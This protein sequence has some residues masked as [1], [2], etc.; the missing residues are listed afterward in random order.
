MK[1]DLTFAAHTFIAAL[2][3]Q[4]TDQLTSRVIVL[5]QQDSQCLHREEP[6]PPNGLSLLVLLLIHLLRARWRAVAIGQ[7][8]FLFPPFISVS[9]SHMVAIRCGAICD[10]PRILV[11]RPIRARLAGATH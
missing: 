2:M 5:H 3:E 7:V 10:S 9:L 11:G 6:L 8:I 4:G 1:L